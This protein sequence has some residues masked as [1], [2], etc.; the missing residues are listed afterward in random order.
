MIGAETS[1]R[2]ELAW[3]PPGIVCLLEILKMLWHAA[4]E[5]F[6]CAQSNFHFCNKIENTSPT[7]KNNNVKRQ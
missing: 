2:R 1:P 3:R 6:G 4:Q 7:D 5:Q